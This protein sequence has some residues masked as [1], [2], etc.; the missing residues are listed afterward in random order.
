MKRL[1][2]TYLHPKFDIIIFF[3]LKKNLFIKLFSG[4]VFQGKIAAQGNLIM[5]DTLMVM[6]LK[7]KSKP[8][9]RRVFLFEQLVIFSEPFERKTDWTVYIYRHSVKVRPV[10]CLSIFKQKCLSLLIN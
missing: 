3:G 6:D 5:Q 2:T 4:I 8:C 10:P 1:Q 7:E 9:K